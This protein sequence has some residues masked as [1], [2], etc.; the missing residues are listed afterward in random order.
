MVPLE[1]VA[2]IID[3][4]PIKTVRFVDDANA[5]QHYKADFESSLD[6]PSEVEVSSIELV[7]GNDWT[8]IWKPDSVRFALSEWR[9][10][11]T[12]M[13]QEARM[14][15]NVALENAVQNATFPRVILRRIEQLQCN[16]YRNQFIQDFEVPYPKLNTNTSSK[17]GFEKVK[18]W[19][20]ALPI[21]ATEHI[22]LAREPEQ[23]L[24]V[25]WSIFVDHWDAFYC[26]RYCTLNIINQDPRWFLFINQDQIAIWGSTPEYAAEK[27]MPEKLFLY[28]PVN[29]RQH[30]LHI[31]QE[32]DKIGE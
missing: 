3:G 15:F 28:D 32:R 8:R 21:L 10:N 7:E 11:H 24:V 26:D 18:S 25:R 6:P 29:Y 16:L 9:S 30:L 1:G 13:P 5:L 31:H 27:K 17:V 19:L 4:T 22:L 14:N 23:T 20:E 2:M 12:A